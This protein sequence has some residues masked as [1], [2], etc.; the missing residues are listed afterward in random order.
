MIKGQ[1]K[2]QN[3]S[4]VFRAT[5]CIDVNADLLCDSGDLQFRN[6]WIFNIPQLLS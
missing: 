3:I 2:P 1:P 5:G 4:D 6:V